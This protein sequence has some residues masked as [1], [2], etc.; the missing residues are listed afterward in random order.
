[1][2]RKNSPLKR[3]NSTLNSAK[4]S[5]RYLAN[6]SRLGGEKNVISDL[7][8]SKELVKKIIKVRKADKLNSGGRIRGVSDKKRS[9][10]EDVEIMADNWSLSGTRRLIYRVAFVA[11]NKIKFVA[12]SYRS[13]LFRIAQKK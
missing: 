6:S 11:L 3:G 7:C 1:M 5:R 4:I 2:N 12:F 9:D 8:L 13:R 10:A